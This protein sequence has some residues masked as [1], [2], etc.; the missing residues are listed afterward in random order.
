M[1]KLFFAA[2][3]LLF[4]LAY[5]ADMPQ[6]SPAYPDAQSIFIRTGGV[7][8]KCGELAK[9]RSQSF[10]GFAE[11]DTSLVRQWVDLALADRSAVTT[12]EQVAE[13]DNFFTKTFEVQ[14]RPMTV[15]LWNVDTNYT[16]INVYYEP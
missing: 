1:R 12:W 2:I 6:T 7:K 10:C 14:E 4:G 8:T 9:G 15:L 11:M 5:A 13:A 3:L 16:V